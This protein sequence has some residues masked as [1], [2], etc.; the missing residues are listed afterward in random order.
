LVVEAVVGILGIVQYREVIRDKIQFLVPLHLLEVV[1]VELMV[2][3]ILEQ[4]EQLVDLVV[5]VDLHQEVL[6]ILPP[7][8]H[9]K[10]IL[11]EVVMEI[12]EVVG[13]DPHL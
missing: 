9:H 2:G 13:E 1:V 7:Q 6:E 10:E 12:M 4:V 11:A 8:H 3:L 5:G